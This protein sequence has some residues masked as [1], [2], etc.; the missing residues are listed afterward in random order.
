[1]NRTA[2]IACCALIGAGAW[3]WHHRS[4]QY[5]VVRGD[6][7]F[8]IARDHGVTVEDLRSWNGL[9]GDLIE[10]GQVL[11]IH[12]PEPDE[13]AQ[14]TSTAGRKRTTRVPGR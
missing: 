8:E 6:T 2:L 9:K 3:W 7:L 5:V 1:M 4:S 14:Q 12:V 11:S 13:A 10:V